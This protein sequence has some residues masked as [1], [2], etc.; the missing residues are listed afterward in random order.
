MMRENRLFCF[1]FTL[2]VLTFS[3][4]L[5]HAEC[6]ID[7]TSMDRG[8]RK[9]FIVCGDIPSNYIIRGLQEANVRIEYA[10]HLGMCGIGVDSPGIY[11]I[12]KAQDDAKTATVRILAGETKEPVCE[13]L[14]IAIQDRVLIKEAS[15][16]DP[17]GPALPFKVLTIKA[18]ASQDLS[19]ACAD[20]L[21]FPRGKWPSPELLSEKEFQEIPPD[22]KSSYSVDGPLTCTQSSVTA[23]VRVHGEQRYPAKIVVPRVK[24]GSGEEKEGVAYAMLPPPKWANAMPDEDA[25]YVDVNGIRTRYY[26]RG[27]GD[28][29]LMV[30]GGQAGSTSNAQ[31][32]EQNI[33]YLSKYFHVYAIDKLGMGYTDNPKT[34]ADYE[35]Y[36]AG[37][38]DHV[39]GFIQ[40]VGIEKVHLIGHS[41]GG[42][43]VTRI[44]VDHP[45]L[46]KSLIVVDSGT[47]APSLPSAR[48]MPL[49]HMYASFYVEPPEGPTL[50]SSRRGI[51]MWSYS[52]NNITNEK[53]ERGYKLSQLPKMVDAG[54]QLRKHSMNPAHPSYRALKKKTLEEIGEGKLK[55]PTFVMWGYNDP[56]TSYKAGIELFKLASSSSPKSQL[57]MFN[58]CGHFPYV[59]YPEL[60]NRLVRDF[61]GTHAY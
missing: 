18:Q 27:E 46:V 48:S 25:K 10:Q 29:L 14:T 36:Y 57:H 4:G 3:A 53:I 2:M 60:F 26:D 1:A 49:F 22:V 20:G 54:K 43:P 23:L 17:A 52:M 13:N 11:L 28:A 45:E 19:Q 41:Q 8:E 33:D 40:A 34:D 16:E 31:N 5:A 47:M 55:V 12:L 42:W 24:L 59:E 9:E 35:N 6:T 56:S 58:N 44:A 15:L 21:S 50:E 30:H 39:Y 37:V 51:E 61:C 7:S 32:W 38:V